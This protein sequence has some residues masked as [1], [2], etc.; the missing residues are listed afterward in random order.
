[1]PDNNS[2]YDL[3]NIKKYLK[4]IN[5]NLLI[6]ILTYLKIHNYDNDIVMY[7]F[8]IFN[9]ICLYDRVHREFDVMIDDKE[10]YIRNIINILNN[11]DKINF[12]R[13]INKDKYFLDNLTLSKKK[14]IGYKFNNIGNAFISKDEPTYTININI[15]K[16]EEDGQINVLFDEVTKNNELF[17]SKFIYELFLMGH[18]NF[19]FYWYVANREMFI[20]ML[21]IGNATRES[22]RVTSSE[23][24]LPTIPFHYNKERFRFELSDD[25]ESSI[26]LY[27]YYKLEYLLGSKYMRD[28]LNEKDSIS[29]LYKTKK[30]LNEKYGDKSFERLY[31]YIQLILYFCKNK[32][33]DEIIS[34]I[35][36]NLSEIEKLNI[37]RNPPYHIANIRETELVVSNILSDLKN[38]EISYE[39]DKEEY[40]K[41]TKKMVSIGALMGDEIKPFI[42]EESYKEELEINYFNLRR[43]E[44]ALENEDIF[45]CITDLDSSIYETIKNDQNDITKNIIRLEAFMIECMKR[46]KDLNNDRRLCATRIS[47]YEKNVM[48]DKFNT[49]IL[50]G[51]K[52]KALDIKTKFNIDNESFIRMLRK[53]I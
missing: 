23:I 19:R 11:I 34:E 26:Y 1:M 15:Y 38:I 16:E 21:L 41:K 17:K 33:K 20:N 39:L 44:Q 10:N 27:L 2:S 42:S 13:D 50:I 31:T 5:S 37:Y 18:K 35:D 40:E 43:I 45:D 47:N 32:S 24:N 49:P 53:Q 51:I 48:D 12:I 30:I 52:K 36:T 29:Y 4:E 25:I 28:W 46:E 9:D 14:E 3:I 6:D 22:R 8:D 7:F